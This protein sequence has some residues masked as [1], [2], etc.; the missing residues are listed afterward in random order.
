AEENILNE[1][2]LK[3]LI[4]K[5]L[6]YRDKQLLRLKEEILDL[7]DLDE[8]LSLSEFSLDDFRMELLRYIEQNKEKLET[9]PLGLYSIVP[10][11]SE[12]ITSK[13]G[14]IF[15]LKQKGKFSE[16]EKVNPVQPYYLVYLQNDGEI[17]YTFVQTKQI[18]E[19][20][21]QLCLGKDT[22]YEKLCQLFNSETD[23]GR[24]M[25]LY[26]NLL[27]KSI[28]VIASTFKK[29]MAADLQNDRGGLLLPQ[30]RQPN[31]EKD[32]ELISW[33]IIK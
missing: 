25:E 2:E 3:E 26:S 24:N 30:S 17:R 7:E 32:F 14:V 22:V 16:N 31:Y 19:I 5:D 8:N 15:C 12:L 21:Q 6:K 4:D 29:R 20:F 18:L 11:S 10:P 33:L 23:Q 13:P 28:Q 9:A 1:D 27:K